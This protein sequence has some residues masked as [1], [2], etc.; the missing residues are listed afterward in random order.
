[1]KKIKKSLKFD[2]KVFLALEL[3]DL[4]YQTGWFTRD[5]AKDFAIELVK[6]I[7]E[8]VTL[9]NKGENI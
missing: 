6:I 3:N 7:E 1:M 9:H 8:R 5:G 4:I 2:K